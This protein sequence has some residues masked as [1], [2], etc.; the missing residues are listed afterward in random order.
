[1]TLAVVIPFIHQVEG[2]LSR[3]VV[4]VAAQ[5]GRETPHV[6]VVNASPIAADNEIA[7]AVDAAGDLSIEVLEQRDGGRSAARNRGLDALGSDVTRVAFLDAGDVWTEGHLARGNAALDAGFDLFSAA[8]P[9]RDYVVATPAAAKQIRASAQSCVGEDNALH[10]FDGNPCDRVLR[11]AAIGT[12]TIVYA[13]ERFRAERFLETLFDSGAE[14]LFW[15]TLAAAGA[16]V[17]FSFEAEVHEAGGDDVESESAPDVHADMRRIQDEMSYRKRLLDLGL[18]DVQRR[19]VKAAIAE[20]RVR[21]A[22]DFVHRISNRQPISGDLL[23]AQLKIDPWT[24]LI[25]PHNAGQVVAE[26]IKA[27][28][29]ARV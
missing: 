20:L 1:M 17:A 5:C 18:S 7:R 11:A 21:F 22:S 26:Q 23:K 6:V 16:R 25:L 28:W 2:A 29:A 15:I 4:S 8:V 19:F 10:D 27:H 12:S 9:S 3:A 14:R 13:F 24:L